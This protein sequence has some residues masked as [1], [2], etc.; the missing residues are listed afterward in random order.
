MSLRSG[1][2]LF[3]THD[4]DKGMSC[5]GIPYRIVSRLVIL[6]QRRLIDEMRKRKG[7]GKRKGRGMNKTRHLAVSL[8]KCLIVG[9]K[10]FN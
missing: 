1:V 8:E 2:T 5:S 7:K 6:A 9:V 10:R 3:G 4:I